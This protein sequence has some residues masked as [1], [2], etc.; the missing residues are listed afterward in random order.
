MTRGAQLFIIANAL[1]FSAIAL[2]EAD[3]ANAAVAESVA[4]G[5]ELS[6]PPALLH[7]WWTEA[8]AP[9]TRGVAIMSPV[10]SPDGPEPP[11]GGDAASIPYYCGYWQDCDPELG[12][13]EYQS[14]GLPNAPR[15]RSA[16]APGDY[17][18]Y[19]G[20]SRDEA[21]LLRL[22][23]AGTGVARGSPA[24]RLPGRPVPPETQHGDRP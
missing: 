5:P 16:Q 2:A 19:T 3:G 8:I 11:V 23:G 7:E 14:T 21:A 18:S 22:G 12:V 4:E 20:A 17:G 13:P 6:A 10:D 9:S 1:S 24:A 15:R